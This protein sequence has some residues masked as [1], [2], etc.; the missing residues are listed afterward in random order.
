MKKNNITKFLI[1]GIGIVILLSGCTEVE[2]TGGGS[3]IKEKKP[4]KDFGGGGEYAAE[5]HTPEEEADA[6]KD[7]LSK[8]S[9]KEGVG[10]FELT[11][12]KYIGDD[13][14][15]E[16]DEADFWLI[17]ENKN[18]FDAGAYVTFVQKDASGKVLSAGDNKT[19]ILKPG[20]RDIITLKFGDG[21]SEDIA[22]IEITAMLRESGEF[23]PGRGGRQDCCASRQARV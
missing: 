22:S 23:K 18:D 14:D 16:E 17:V 6:N 10:D 13:D 7:F 15:D 12:I 19:R 4:F 5:I 1:L 9:L 11:P 3:L 2:G 21:I 20:S 8:I